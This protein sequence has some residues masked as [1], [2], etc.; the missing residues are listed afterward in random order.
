MASGARV[1]IDV[2]EKRFAVLPEPL[3]ENLTFKVEPSSTVA[4]VGPSGVGKSTLLR[5]I[6]G[7]DADFSG[8]IHI[9]EKPARR[10]AT[11]G[12]VFQDPR[13][14]PWLS[15]S[16]NIR[17]VRAGITGDTANGLLYE[18][19]LQGFENALP[20]ELSGGMQRRVALARSLA[21]EPQLLLLDEPFVSLDKKL[22]HELH[23]VF[24]RLVATY[25]PTVI[26][27]SHDADDAARLADRVIVMEGK[28]A[29]IAGDLHLDN[30]PLQRSEDD[31]GRITADITAQTELF[32]GT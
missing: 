17:A 31:V 32:D 1:D 22:T 5:L 23:R 28:P 2:R 10:A 24:A 18:V 29:R 9:D 8:H 30:A 6:A 4:L 26:M 14:L 15:A 27:V 19:G 3:F 16:A 13:L 7:I 21:I 12:F 25:K 20:H 11:P